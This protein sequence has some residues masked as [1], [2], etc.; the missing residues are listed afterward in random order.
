VDVIDAQA[1]TPDTANQRFKSLKH[2]G[3]LA[4]LW[5]GMNLGI[6]YGLEWWSPSPRSAT[7]VSWRVLRAY[8]PRE[9]IA[10]TDHA[11]ESRLLYRL[12]EPAAT[13]GPQPLLII[14]H[15]SGQRGNDNQQQ[16]RGLPSQLIE[17]TWRERCPGFVLVP[18]CPRAS[19]WVQQLPA[20]TSLIESWCNDPRV[21]RR[22]VYVTGL[23][24]GGYGVWHLAACQPDWFSAAVPICG[25]GDPAAAYQTR[26]RVRS[27]MVGSMLVV[28]G[29]LPPGTSPRTAVCPGGRERP[30]P[31]HGRRSP[32]RCPVR[33]HTE[34]HPTLQS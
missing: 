9:W 32:C 22:R 7:Q 15:G 5:I 11:N 25:G 10:S 16:L 17:A 8:Q 26:V 4:M 6:I 20:L 29:R 21:D 18:Q 14:L 24:M 23:S 30:G 28:V 31:E 27:R 12:M 33:R 2:W 19:D 3:L 1:A 34:E 13:S